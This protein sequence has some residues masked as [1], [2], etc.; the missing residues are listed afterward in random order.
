MLSLAHKPYQVEGRSLCLIT[1]KYATEVWNPHGNGR[2]HAPVKSGSL[3]S[4]PWEI[5]MPQGS[6]SYHLTVSIF[7][8]FIRNLKGKK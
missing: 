5:P 2:T 6:R 8:H 7:P 1:F 4:A 3:Q